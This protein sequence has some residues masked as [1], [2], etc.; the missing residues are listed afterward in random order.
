MIYVVRCS[1][2]GLRKIGV[3]KDPARRIDELQTGSASE[4]VLELVAPGDMPDEQRLHKRFAAK[5]VRG[6]WFNIELNELRSVEWMCFFNPV[7]FDGKSYGEIESMA[8]SMRE[9]KSRNPSVA[10]EIRERLRS[11]DADA[12]RALEEGA[13][14]EQPQV[15][16]EYELYLSYLEWKLWARQFAAN[17]RALRA[18]LASR[19]P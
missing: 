19:A 7:V 13:A 14:S 12:V 17:A 8:A 9:L 5:R 6:E 11:C 15:A 3:A 2:T 18:F 1:A 4:L 16:K 10:S